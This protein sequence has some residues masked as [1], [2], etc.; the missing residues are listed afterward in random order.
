MKKRK[1]SVFLSNGRNI[2]KVKETHIGRVYQLL[3]R[4]NEKAANW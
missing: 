2:P 4:I 3:S 1:S